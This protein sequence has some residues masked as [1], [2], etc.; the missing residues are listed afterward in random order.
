VKAVPERVVADAR[1]K[2]KVAKNI[3]LGKLVI[4]IALPSMQD[5]PS[6]FQRECGDRNGC[7]GMK[8]DRMKGGISDQ[9]EKYSL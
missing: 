2:L 5:P 3:A 4:S 9:A 1:L 6:V 8:G 7:H